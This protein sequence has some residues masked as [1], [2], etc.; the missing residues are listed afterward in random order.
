MQYRFVTRISQP[1]LETR[2]FWCLDWLSRQRMPCKLTTKLAVE[3]QNASCLVVICERS[4]MHI[5]ILF[6]IIS[7][8]ISLILWKKKKYYILY[9]SVIQSIEFWFFFCFIFYFFARGGEFYTQRRERA[10]YYF[11]YSADNT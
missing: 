7:H 3:P 8:T 11:Y 4:Y 10:H 9:S 6:V 2:P 1:P 5:C